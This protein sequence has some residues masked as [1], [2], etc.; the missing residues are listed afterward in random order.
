[1]RAAT[2]AA[3]LALAAVGAPLS[4][5]RAQGWPVTG[6]DAGGMRYSPLT[7]IDRRNVGALEVAWTW[8]TGETPIART[9]STLAARPGAF[10]ATPLMIGDTLFLSTPYNR[11]VAL[12]AATGRE[13][14]SYDPGAYRAGQ[15]SNG[16]GFVHRGVAAWSDG[17]T[18]RIFINSRWRLIAL[19]AATGKPVATF[20]T[21][22]EVDL[23]AQ[24]T[25]PVNRRHYTNT[26]PPVV[27]GDLVIVGNG[28][29]DRLAYRNDPPGDVQAFDVRTGRRVWRFS[30]IPQAGE[31]GNETWEDSSWAYTGHTNVWAPFTADT[32]RGLLY[33]PVSTPSNDWY[34]GRRK[35]DNLFAESIVCLD[36]RTGKRVWHYQLVHHG[37]WDYDLPAPPNLVTIRPGGTPIDAVA[38]PTKMGY[39]FVFDRV[40]GKPV[41]PIEERLVPPSDV[42]GER[43]AR[44]QPHPTRPAPFAT[45]GFNEADVIDFTP[46][47]RARALEI[48]RPYRLG[49]MYTP[50]SLEGTVAMPGVIG[51]SGWGGGA[52]DP[53]T[54]TLYVKATNAPAL[55]KLNRVAA[56][57]DTVDADYMLDL[58]LSTLSVS[59]GRPGDTLGLHQPTE[60]LPINKPP[61]GTLTA[62]DMDTGEHR[63]QVP[64]GDT[65]G[66]RD[67]PLLRGVPLPPRLGVAGAPGGI[68][69][70]GGLVFITGGGSTLYAIDKADGKTLWQGELGARGY[71]NPMTYRTRTGR[72][73]VVIATGAG[74]GAKLVAF[75][76]PDARTRRG[77]AAPASP[78]S[79]TTTVGIE[80]DFV[81]RDFRF[82]DGSVLPELRIHYT[83]LGR[84]RR[85]AAGTVRNAVL[86]LHGTTGSGRGFLSPAF[87]GELFGPGQPLDTATHYVILPDGIGTGGSSKPSDG[88]HARFPRYGYEDMVTAQHRLVTEGLGVDHLRLVMGTSMGGMQTWM[89]GVR[90]PDF[91]DALVPLASVPTQIAGRNRMMRAMISDAI[92]GDPAWRRGEYTTPPP[93]LS[94]ALGMLFMM[95]S[96]PLQLQAAAATRDS[97]D[98]YIAGWM[99]TRMASTDANDFL[100]QFE[101]SRDYDPSPRLGRIRAPVLAINSADDLVNPP[102]LGLME[103]LM[104][105]VTRGRYVLIP[106]GAR[107]RGHGTHSLPALWKS[108]LAELLS[109]SE[110]AVRPTR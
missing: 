79:P 104:P 35:G 57:S 4:R 54:R 99:R 21:G 43:A 24:L 17:R 89:W 75:A 68:V 103:R 63:W 15:P 2:L 65:P 55:F 22:G 46:E 3:F 67:H 7:G 10:Q 26:S 85:D 110:R 92:R 47:L 101:A 87:A 74:A 86:V 106:T 107:T 108:H 33:L 14:W 95:T 49:P 45:Q 102:E 18:R 23:T 93:G 34:G 96:S 38:V 27:V 82:G 11:V 32:A 20:G 71:A 84:P 48:L 25:R 40:T 37:L 77:D 42:P 1:M 16:T 98:A 28:V 70:R 76:L 9:D 60:A 36:A 94:T 62:I 61:Y 8:A 73:F 5:A 30:P 56:P 83:T 31:F 52:F 90:Y 13:L 69:T 50:P 81:M 72:Q 64:L 100:Y 59:P 66:V 88:L 80:G 58:G 78:A 51:G 105:R 91:M 44:T 109:E 19:D 39:L 6:G 12:D 29:G 97:A 41:W 53:E